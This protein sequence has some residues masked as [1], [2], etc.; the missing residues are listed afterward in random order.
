MGRPVL[1]DPAELDPEHQLTQRSTASTDGPGV[2]PRGHR[3]GCGRVGREPDVKEPDRG[4]EVRGVT[5]PPRSRL[6][7]SA[8]CSLAGYLLISVV[9]LTIGPRALDGHWDDLGYLYSGTVLL[10]GHGHAAGLAIYHYSP[11]L[12]IG[13]ATFAVC[14]ALLRLA[15]Y[16]FEGALVG[17]GLVTLLVTV[18]ACE[19]AACVGQP[20]AGRRAIRVATIAGGCALALGWAEL[21]S[22]WGH[23]DDALSLTGLALAWWSVRRASGPAELAGLFLGLAVA[24]KPIAVCA[25][26][27]VM[28]LPDVSQRLRGLAVAVGLAALG[29]LP[30]VAVDPVATVSGLASVHIVVTSGSVIHLLLPGAHHA[31]VWTRPAQLALAVAGAWLAI[32]RGRPECVLLVVLAARILLDSGDYGYYATELMLGAFV[33]EQVRSPNARAWGA[34]GLRVL[35]PWVFLV[36]DVQAIR[37]PDVA[38]LLVLLALVGT[39]WVRPRT[40]AGAEVSATLLPA[41]LPAGVAQ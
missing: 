3:L 31:P 17:A 36:F 33:V 28:V 21:I 5:R 41:R 1:P 23:L 11:V 9:Y 10:T 12:Q 30:F 22:G 4:T 37:P 26:P 19:A 8:V 14:A 20:P 24:A 40:S 38:R 18:R 27:M 34:V 13:P 25:L 32:R 29:F 7:W 35:L 6:P 2:I 15:P 16:H 39:C